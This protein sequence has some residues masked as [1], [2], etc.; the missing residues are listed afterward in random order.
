M[1]SVKEHAYAKINL[2]LDVTGKRDDGF[3][4]VKTVMHTIS[5]SDE[6]TVSVKS[7]SKREVRLTLAGNQRIPQDSRNLAYRAAELFLS[8]TLIDAEVNIRLN[9]RIPV[10]AGLAGGSTDAAAVLRALNR[11]F[12][13][14]LTDKRLL[15]LAAELG[16]DVP[17][18]LIGGT[19]LCLGRGEQM[20]RLSGGLHL[21]VLVA[22]ADEYVSTP[23]AY[24]SLDE[25]YD[26]FKAC[27]EDNSE[28]YF[29]SLEESIKNGSLGNFELYNIFEKAVFRTCF[30]AETLKRKMCELGAR[31]ALMSGSGPS[32][33]G[34]FEDET[35]LE[36]AR[37]ELENAGFRAFSAQSV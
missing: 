20:E 22:V 10:A 3:H 8:A 7:S 33:F 30:G 35:T 16:S 1:N 37:C 34:I 6:I 27:R 29:T 31:Q 21:Y 17:F 26:G 11:A 13:K 25:L 18:C 28:A 2:Y 4:D 5:L 15:S 9:K 23:A 19:A 12:K 32:V 36:K 24:A 14:P